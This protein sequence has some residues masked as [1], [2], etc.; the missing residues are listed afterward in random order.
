MTHPPWSF[1]LIYLD[2]NKNIDPLYLILR[3]GLVSIFI[4]GVA[5]EPYSLIAQQHNLAPWNCPNKSK[6]VFPSKIVVQL[7]S[8]I[9]ALRSE[10]DSFPFS[11]SWQDLPNSAKMLPPAD[12]NPYALLISRLKLWAPQ[13]VSA[14]KP[15]P[16]G[17]T[18]REHCWNNYRIYNYME[19]H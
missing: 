3:E 12:P 9:L 13:Q 15:D 18:L 6:S 7:A 11:C 4:L 2:S 5:R 19:I 10:A 8:N 1:R 16:A 14:C 17:V